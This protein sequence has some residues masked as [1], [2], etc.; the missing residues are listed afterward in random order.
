MS[1]GKIANAKCITEEKQLMEQGRT[2]KQYCTITPEFLSM[3]RDACVN[4]AENLSRRT[5][6]F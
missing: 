6:I 5:E 3:I 1:I 2:M 4:E